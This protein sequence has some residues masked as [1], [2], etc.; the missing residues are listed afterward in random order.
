[1]ADIYVI[2]LWKWFVFA[3]KWTDRRNQRGQRFNHKH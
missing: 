1:M 3:R 2:Y